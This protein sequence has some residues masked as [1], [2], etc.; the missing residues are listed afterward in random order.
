[1][2]NWDGVPMDMFDVYMEVGDVKALPAEGK[3]YVPIEVWVSCCSAR[4]YIRPECR[5]IRRRPV[6]GVLKQILKLSGDK[7][8]LLIFQCDESGIPGSDTVGQSITLYLLLRELLKLNKVKYSIAY[9]GYYR[10]QVTALFQSRFRREQNRLNC[11]NFYRCLD[12]LVLSQYN[13]YA[14][15]PGPKILTGTEEIRNA[16]GLFP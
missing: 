12:V 4:E 11:M 8:A 5:D 13:S 2:F 6:Y 10:E 3:D 14:H 15:S 7:Q 9:T 1:M 16:L